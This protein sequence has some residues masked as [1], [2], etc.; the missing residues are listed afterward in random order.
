M[1]VVLLVVAA[2][3]QAPLTA[4]AGLEE[5]ARSGD[6]K[7]VL[8]VASRRAGQLPLSPEESL[9]AAYAARSLGARG[10][11]GRFLE[12]VVAHGEGG[13]ARLAEVQL[14]EL[15]G[16]DQ[17]DRA[18]LLAL[19]SLSHAPSR[20][21]NEAAVRVA[22]EALADG[23]APA[24][25]AALEGALHRLS[26][27]P[28]RRLELALAVGDEER[29]RHRLERLLASST[30]DT[31]AL[32]AAEA[33]MEMG[34][35]STVEQWRV[36]KT[37]YRHALYEDAAPL[38][39]AVDGVRHAAVPGEEVAYLR[40]RCAFRRERWN[41]AMTWY[42][43]AM[44][45]TRRADRR[46]E[47]EVHISRCHELSGRMDEAVAAAQR[48]VRLK[49]TDERR[50][51]LARLRLRR[52][53]P[54]LAA[55]GISRLRGK[56]AR[57]RGQL[58]L[59]VDDLRRS[60]PEAA[61][62]RL[63]TIRRRPW[64]GQAAVLA[65][66]LAVEDGDADSA[67]K[68]LDG[69]VSSLNGYWGGQAREVMISLPEAHT[70]AWRRERE[71]AVV[72]AS[73]RSLRRALGRWMVMEP[74][75]ESRAAIRKRVADEVGFEAG[76][77]PRFVPG[78]AQQ[79]WDLGLAG[80]AVL[81][82]PTGFPRGNAAAASW[83][84]TRLLEFGVPWRAIR[85]ADGAWHMA[86]SELPICAFPVELQRAFFPLPEPSMVARAADDGGVPWS[87]LAAVVRE[88]S[89]WDPKAVSVV[90]ARGLVQ[91]MPATASMVAE[92]LEEEAPT[93]DD[94]FEPQTSLRLGAAELARLLEVFEG[95]LA[96][97]VAAYNA[98]EPQA[99][100]WADQCG[101]NCSASL[102]LTNISFT[103]TRVYTT[104]VL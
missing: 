17:P 29:G 39:E 99:R 50:L 30:G 31:V 102:Y 7:R 65:A 91:L 96:P 11:E 97:A 59:A 13:L 86:G 40:G 89:R 55:K 8:E 87:L 100:L 37:L 36:A 34:D 63:E 26:R 25:R 46:A 78:L 16:G 90:G 101:V 64:A 72:A 94:L 88:E 18:V 5:L 93:P 3:F 10:A 62:R 24:Q 53:E 19:P 41:E 69:V 6:F 74:D 42:T 47:L 57:A 14:A 4:W 52:G 22:S 35:L 83:S 15:V 104:D 58:M 43:K 45:R 27:S 85:M 9:I 80:E 51:F 81:W 28:R 77:E 38:L 44:S 84:A 32:S 70:E 75:A 60:E 56:T 12:G 48:A 67:V 54:E 71:M 73:G 20:Q 33:L 21:V 92:A 95:R 98:G 82:D 68:L 103:A 2:L 79:L 1:S 49:T 23:V 61:R 66:G 76:I